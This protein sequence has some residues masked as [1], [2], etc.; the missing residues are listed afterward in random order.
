MSSRG[1][2]RRS[3]LKATAGTLGLGAIAPGLWSS[4]ASASGA[5][6]ERPRIG[7]IGMRYQGSVITEKALP[8]GD[9]VAVCD[10][11]RH[12]REQARASFGSLLAIY[13]DYHE[14][15]ARDDIDVVLIGA[16][17]HWHAPMTIDACRAGKDVYC[18]KPSTLTIDEGKLMCKVVE[19]TG[20][21]VQ[22]GTWQRSDWKFRLAAELV[23]AGRI[24]KL[25]EVTVV[26]DKNVV[27]GPFKTQDPPSHLNWDLWLG[28]APKVPYTPERCHYTFRW[29]LEYAGGKM[30][31]WGA[32]HMDIA[33]WAI[34]EQLSGPVVIESTSLFPNVPNGYNVPI[35]FGARLTY[36]NGV[37]L[38][39]LDNGKNGITFRGD[40]G[41]IFVSRSE[42]TGPAVDALEDD[43]LPREDYRMYAHD[44][45]TSEP[46]TGKLASLVNHME[47]FFDCVRTRKPPISDVVS[48]HR[49]ASICHLANISM[50]LGR[51]LRWDP[52]YERFVYDSEAN[53]KLAR[54]QREGY[55]I[56]A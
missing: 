2:N 14:L 9:V 27:G 44:L 17:D 41:S 5:K 3:F 43:P 35:D 24:G 23:Q 10:V 21:V 22:V 19:E 32:H 39:L 11:D 45:P 4:G 20:A 51:T 25:R 6:N 47:N 29:W 49:S 48:Q 36:A 40:D 38:V 33:Q 31:D 28:Q 13:E 12:V 18:E 42:V 37:E 8:H 30:T 16:P 7:A 1:K 55:E 34:G 26:I 54:E 15:L 56:K 46:R 52:E 50:E 53:A